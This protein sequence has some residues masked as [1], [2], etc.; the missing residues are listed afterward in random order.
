MYKIEKYNHVNV[1]G[2]ALLLDILVNKKNQ[3]KK[4]ILS[5]SRAVYGEGKYK[6]SKKE[7]VF[8][9]HRK[10]D[11]MK[12][13]MFDMTDES[14][15]I[16]QVL[17]TDES[18]KLQP[19]SFYGITK[20]QQE[21]IVQN[22]CRSIGLNFVILR[23][24]NVYGV[25]QSLKNPYTGILSIFSTQIL[26]GEN[27]NIFEDGLPTRDFINIEDTVET[28]IRALKM[29]TANSQIINVGTGV[30]T[31]VLRV[32]EILKN[33]YQKNTAIKITGDFRIGDIRHNIAS[34]GK[35]KN[36]LNFEPK[37][38]FQE[39]VN[40]FADWVLTQPI[41]ENNLTNSLKEMQEKGFLKS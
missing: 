37:I 38:N 26:N 1:Y 13:G 23:Y 5:S 34:L 24:Q 20:L 16:L 14:G 27:L 39:G 31:S 36:L 35:M 41:E 32:A 28:T 40:D 4:F 21:Q 8:P 15:E 19:V 25:G 7:I 12:K 29:E 2:T 33:K 18:S 17:E 6:N 10:V 30:G 11:L 22:V 3:V 9:E